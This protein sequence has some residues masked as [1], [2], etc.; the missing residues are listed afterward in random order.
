GGRRG[1]RPHSL[2]LQVQ[3]AAGPGGPGRGVPGHEAVRGPGRGRCAERV[4]HVQDTAQTQPRHA[5]AVPPAHRR[6]PA[7]QRGRRGSPE[8]PQRGP[9]AHRRAREAGPRRTRGRSGARQRH[10][11]GDRGGGARD[12]DPE[13]RRP[14]FQCRRG[15]RCTHCDVFVRCIQ[16]CAGSTGLGRGI[17][18]E[19][20][21]RFVY[22]NRW[23]TLVGSGVVLAISVVGLLMG[24]TLTSGGPRTSNLESARAGNLVTSEL[25]AV[26]FTSSFDLILRS[27]T[28][29]VGEAAYQSAL[30]DAIAPLQG[31]DRILTLTTPYNVTSP[32]AVQALTSKDGH[33][34][35]VVVEL[36]SSGHQSWK[37]YADLKGKIHTST[38]TITGNGFVPINQAFNTTLETDLQRAEYV[39][40]PITLLLLV[41][42]FAGIVAAGLPLGVGLLTIVGGVGGTFY[43]NHFTDVSQYALNIVTLIGLGVS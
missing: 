25:G 38:L 5:R 35:L 23:A 10:C 19:R 12:H 30:T 43:L 33:E 18:F 13:P 22:R 40:L 27:D 34:A 2:L 24:G 20:W 7:R 42:I 1:A 31:D 26:K 15:R 37:D 28:L 39:S 11:R 17:V 21:G 41:I 4:R 32:R 3:A 16:L 8:F 29:S 36:K 14:Q 9:R 6:R